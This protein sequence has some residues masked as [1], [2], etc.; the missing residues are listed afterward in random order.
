MT[1]ENLKYHNLARAEWVHVLIRKVVMMLNEKSV[2]N[3]SSISKT[4]KKKSLQSLPLKR[5]PQNYNTRM[6]AIKSYEE[7]DSLLPPMK[8]IH[9]FFFLCK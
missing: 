6:Y 1:V 7:N 5:T 3:V 9:L 4:K 8:T 2:R